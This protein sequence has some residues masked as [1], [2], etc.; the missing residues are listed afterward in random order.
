MSSA[1]VQTRVAL[2]GDREV[3]QQLRGV[4]TSF[5]GLAQGVGGIIPS[6]SALG[7]VGAAVGAGLLVLR[8]QLVLVQ[9]ASE[10]AARAF[11]DLARRGS[12]VDAIASR[13]ARLAPQET[14]DRMVALTGHQV[15]ARDIMRSYAQSIEVGLVPAAEFE[16]WLRRIT[17]MAHGAGEDPAEWLERFSEVL[18]GGG[19][20]NM[21]R[22]GVNVQQVQ[23][24]VREMGLSMES[25][26]GRTVALELSAKQLD[27]RMGSVHRSATNLGQAWTSTSNQLGDYLDRVGRVVATSP[28]LIRALESITGSVGGLAPAAEMAGRAITIMAR[29]LITT[30]GGAAAFIEGVI[31]ET[32]RGIADTLELF[33]ELVSMP[34]TG[35]P[36]I[37]QAR[38]LLPSAELLSRWE[39]TARGAEA[40]SQRLRRALDEMTA[41]A[42]GSPLVAGTQARGGAGGSQF[43]MQDLKETPGRPGGGGGG[44]DPVL[45]MQEEILE[46]MRAREEGEASRAQRERDDIAR[47]AMVQR[48]YQDGI[49]EHLRARKDA[50]RDLH[51]E[52]MAAAQVEA[53]Q[54]R[55]RHEQ[56]IADAEEKRRLLMESV[57]SYFSGIGQIAGTTEQVVGMIGDRLEQNLATQISSLEAM[58]K[59]RQEIAAL[60]KEQAKNVATWRKVEGVALGI[61]YA[62]EGGGEIAKSIGSYPDPIG[63]ATHAASA[64]MYFVQSGLA[65]SQLAQSGGGAAGAGAATAKATSSFRPSQPDRAQQI[66]TRPSAQAATI[67]YYSLGRTSS[68]LGRVL[69]EADWQ[70]ERTGT[71][72]QTPRG[73]TY[74]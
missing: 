8:T 11:V 70:R 32:A 1:T 45:Q 57:N 68:D 10:L 7:G 36:G 18:S 61:K 39:D 65:F 53:E 21:R 46:R 16:Q 54:E 58:G 37:E 15:R 47:T 56:A 35:I 17:T 72:A 49:F 41:A 42:T 26:R 73:V 40:T 14:L 51:E 66:N 25:A 69:R 74:G 43:W 2:Q 67:H 59:N 30:F 20:E 55:Q 44:T 23:G 50:D 6:L 9:R 28:A 62:I 34:S 24:A 3:K 27:A 19:L 71:Q 22:L 60:T 12:E 33:G 48:A 63:I 38:G 31:A 64:A 29:N 13:F 5:R 52:R 4:E